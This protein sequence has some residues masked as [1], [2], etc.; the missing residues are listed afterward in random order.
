M[1]HAIKVGDSATLTR[2][3]TEVDVLAFAD[4]VDDHNR[5]HLDAEYA[6]ETPFK[7]RIMHGML[8]GC[9]FSA[10]LGERLPGHGAVYLGQSLKFKSP[11]HFGM[12]V[13][14]KVEVTVIRHDKGIVTMAT[15]CEDNEGKTLVTGEAVLSVP[16]LRTP[17][18]GALLNGAAS[19]AALQSS[20]P[21]RPQ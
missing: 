16:W 3:F 15:T 14:A 9:L 1:S 17:V 6:A 13:I 4:L 20:R 10:L 2:T 19:R 7:Q 8:V 11:V 18:A 12:K 21:G 5:I